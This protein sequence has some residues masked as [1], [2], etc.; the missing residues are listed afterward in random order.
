MLDNFVSV[1][2][3]IARPSD[4]QHWNITKNTQPKLPIEFRNKDMQS[5]IYIYSKS[6]FIAI[7]AF[8][9]FLFLN[10]HAALRKL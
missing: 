1:Y 7:F 5:F 6:Y 8:R 9:S 4:L 3:V 10:S 2:T